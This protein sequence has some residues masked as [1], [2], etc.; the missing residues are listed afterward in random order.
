V[1]IYNHINPSKSVVS[2]VQQLSLQ[3]LRFRHSRYLSLVLKAGLAKPV[4]VNEQSKLY[5]TSADNTTITLN[6]GG[7]AISKGSEKRNSSELRM[8]YNLTEDDFRFLSGKKVVSAKID[9]V[10]GEWVLNIDN[11]GSENIKKACVLTQ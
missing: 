5:L 3:T 4:L 1:T 11:D 6:S 2:G 8:V 7:K 9:Y 10:G